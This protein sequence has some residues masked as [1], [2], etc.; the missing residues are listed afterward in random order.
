MLRVTLTLTMLRVTLTLLL[1]LLLTRAQ[2]SPSPEHLT[3]ALAL[4]PNPNPEQ[5]YGWQRRRA[6]RLWAQYTARSKEAARARRRGDD[7]RRVEAIGKLAARGV[8]VR[9]GLGLGL[10]S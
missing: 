9:L 10:E 1:T 2:P 3:L 4:A 7:L 5:V 8:R 6:M